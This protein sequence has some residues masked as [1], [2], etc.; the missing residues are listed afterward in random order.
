MTRLCASS[1]STLFMPRMSRCSEPG[2][3]ICPP[4]LKRP[5]PMET[6]PGHARS[7][8]WISPVERGRRAS[9]TSTGFNCETSLI[10]VLPARAGAGS[11]AATPEAAAA[12]RISR[13]LGFTG[14][15]L[16]RAPCPASPWLLPLRLE[17]GASGRR[18]EE[19][20]QRLCRRRV[21]RAHADAGMEDGVVLQCGRQR[22]QD[23][24]AGGGHQFVDED[25]AELDF[26]RRDEL[27][28]FDAR[29][30]GDDFPLHPFGDADA[31]EQLREVDAALAFFR[32]GD[33][34]RGEE[35]A[36]ERLL[37]ADVRAP[38]ALLD[39][40]SHA[41]AGDRGAG[42]RV[43]LALL[44]EVVERGGGEY[45]E[46]EAFAPFDLAL[47]SRGEAEGDR[48][49]VL[50][51][52]LEGGRELVQR[53]LHAVGGE[54]LDFGGGDGSR[55]EHGCDRGECFEVHFIS[56]KFRAGPA[57]R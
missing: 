28:D 24:D 5:P 2:S 48:H 19:L 31:L 51:L 37:R 54:D 3:A 21:L 1:D 43:H 46:V 52:A 23:F 35:R 50:G 20:D 25:D 26:P 10:T 56:L 45:G 29:G 42:A 39:S 4:W 22:P 18:G 40:D 55:G 47:Q 9:A 11:R 34:I 16:S 7:A 33:G 15:R 36:P 57:R 30:G 13:R 49:L 38:R 41:R 8:A 6:V 12:L 53:L 44:R 27:A 32:P 17:H 14:D